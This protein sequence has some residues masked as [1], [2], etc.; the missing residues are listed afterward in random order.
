MDGYFKNV[1]GTVVDAVMSRMNAYGRVAMCGAI[2]G[3]DDASLLMANPAL[4]LILCLKVQEFTMPEHMNDWPT[5]LKQLGALVA[6]GQPKMRESI[7]EGLA[8]TPAAF[9]DLL[10]GHFSASSWSGW[11]SVHAGARGR[12]PNGNAALE[13]FA[14]TS[15]AGR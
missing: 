3:Y 15:G 12:P 6:A 10:K 14:A 1:G 13:G 2:A 9:L 5:A 4:I 8:S 7:A 11:C